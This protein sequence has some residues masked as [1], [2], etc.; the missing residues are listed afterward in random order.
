MHREA[1]QT[2]AAIEGHCC[3]AT[4]YSAALLQWSELLHCMALHRSTVCQCTVQSCTVKRCGSMSSV[5][6]PPPDANY[7]SSTTILHLLVT[8]YWLRTSTTCYVLLFPTWIRKL[9]PRNC[10]RMKEL[11]AARSFQTQDVAC[12]QWMVA[13]RI[14]DGG[15]VCGGEVFVCK[16]VEEGL[17][18][19]GEG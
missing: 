5:K 10:G 14:L 19:S 1:H 3:T 16:N 7:L 11:E 4:L 12:G 9:I 18:R 8:Y 6:E 17:L 15:V 13:V 2:R